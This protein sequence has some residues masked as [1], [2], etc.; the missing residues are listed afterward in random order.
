MGSRGDEPNARIP[1]S[2]SK[3]FAPF[4]QLFNTYLIKLM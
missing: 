3:Q 1:A 4:P 2:V